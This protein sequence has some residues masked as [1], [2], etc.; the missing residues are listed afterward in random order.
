MKIKNFQVFDEMNQAAV[1]ELMKNDL[2]G[3]TALKVVKVARKLDEFL[4]DI[5]K[6]VQIIREKYMEKD[7]KGNPIHPVENG[8]VIKDRIK[9][10]DPASF[11]KELAE[12]L[13]VENEIE[14]EQITEEEIKG[15]KISPKNLMVLGWLIKQ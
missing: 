8:V 9:I 13:S 10:S 2:V 15:V 6:S 5:N 11:Q 4:A 1:N 7:E 12:I 14:G 3:A